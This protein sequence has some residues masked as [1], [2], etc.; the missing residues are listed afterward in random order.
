MPSAADRTPPRSR[1]AVR[2]RCSHVMYIS[3][4]HHHLI[5]YVWGLIVQGILPVHHVASVSHFIPFN[6][7]LAVRTRK[8]LQHF[9]LNGSNVFYHPFVRR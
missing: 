6:E 4:P 7:W 8:T 9:L 3:D 5:G 2:H 1:A